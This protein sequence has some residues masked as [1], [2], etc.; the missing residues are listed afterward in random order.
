VMNVAVLSSCPLAGHSL[1]ADVHR[2][3]SDVLFLCSWMLASGGD[4]KWGLAERSPLGKRE[5][6]E[7]DWQSDPPEEA[8]EIG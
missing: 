4:E 2:R 5:K 1:S 6:R 7:G 8:E 3:F